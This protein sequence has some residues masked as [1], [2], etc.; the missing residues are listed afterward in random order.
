LQF[1]RAAE[2]LIEALNESFD[3]QHFWELAEIAK[4]LGE[5]GDRR[6]LPTLNNVLDNL[7]NFKSDSSVD[8][9]DWD[10]L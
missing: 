3:R 4:A 8:V 1:P 7:N 9:G 2:A 10:A 6:T 5:I